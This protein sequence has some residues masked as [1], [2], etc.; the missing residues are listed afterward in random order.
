MQVQGAS[1][2]DYSTNRDICRTFSGGRDFLNGA[3][4]SFCSATQKFVTLSVTEAEIAAGSC[5]GHTACVLFFGV[6]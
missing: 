4:I 3:S 6:A 2:S 1:E 5:A